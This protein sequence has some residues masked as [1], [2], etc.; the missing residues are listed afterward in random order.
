MQKLDPVLS[1][2]FTFDIVTLLSLQEK[3]IIAASGVK[4]LKKDAFQRDVLL[5]QT[6]NKALKQERTKYFYLVSSTEAY[7]GCGL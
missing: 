6:G 5:F 7:F 2:D 3:N 1:E 4:K